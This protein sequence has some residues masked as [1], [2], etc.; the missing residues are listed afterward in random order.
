MSA[1]YLDSCS[2]PLNK[3]TALVE[4]SAGTG[5]TFAI[6]M[7]VLRA[8]TELGIPIREVLV[9]TYTKA[10]TEELRERIRKRFIEARTLVINKGEG[11]TDPVLKE[12]FDRM[13]D[14]QLVKKRLDD[15]LT[16]IDLTEIFT[17]HGFC[18]R[19]LQEHALESGQFFETELLQDT[20]S[21]LS[22]VIEDY[23]RTRVYSLDEL[24][25]RLLVSSYP[26]PEKLYK[27]INSSGIDDA[28]VI[29]ESGGIEQCSE[30]LGRAFK[31]L[32]RWF[33][34]H[35]AE[36]LSH[37]AAAAAEGKFKKPLADPEGLDVVW[38]AL[39]RFFHGEGVPEDIDLLS[40]QG[41]LERLNGRKVKK[42]KQQAF[43][44]S[45]PVADDE[46][47]AFTLA[48]DNLKLSFREDLLHHVQKELARRLYDL[49]ALSFNDLI[50]R[51]DHALHSDN[52]ELA[53]LIGKRYGAAFIDEFQDTDGSQWSIFSTLFGGGS[54]YFYLIGDP[55]QAIYKFRGAD[56]HSY[57]QARQSADYQYTLEKNYRSHPALVE[58]INHL[59][60]FS[61]KPFNYEVDRLPFHA[62]EA[63]KS[64]GEIGLVKDGR[65]LDTL[66]Y[67]QLPE[68]LES[69]KHDWKTGQARELFLRRTVIEITGLLADETGVD[70]LAENHSGEVEARPLQP[71]DIAILVRNHKEGR[72]YQAALGEIGLP[73]VIA[74]KTSV[75]SSAEC[76]EL[77]LVLD[78]IIEPANVRKLKSAMAVSWFGLTGNE[79]EALWS[80]EALFGSWFDRFLFYHQL[81]QEKGFLVMIYT[82]LRDEQV[83]LHLAAATQG[84]RR[85]TNIYHLIELVSEAEVEE[86]LG[87]SQTLSLLLSRI[88]DARGADDTELRLES[89]EEAVQIVT[90]HSAKGLQY[91]VV[92]CPC[93]WQRAAFL[94][95]EKEIVSF[96]SE[97]GLVVDIGSEEFEGHKDIALGEELAEELRLLYVA[98]TRAEARC[99]IMWADCGGDAW[100]HN[101]FES[102]LGYILFGGEKQDHAGQAAVLANFADNAGVH[103]ELLSTG[104]DPFGV[105]FHS[106]ESEPLS[107]R[108]R[109]VRRFSTDFR[110]SSYSA[111]AAL[112]EHQD[113][114]SYNAGQPEVREDNEV[115][116]ILHT[117][118]PAGASFGNLIH[119]SLEDIPFRFFDGRASTTET[120]KKLCQRYGL[121]V[122]PGAI[123]EFLRSG[124]ESRVG[125]AEELFSL[126]MLDE[127]RCL[128]EM[129][130]YFQVNNLNT[131]GINDILSHDPAVSAVSEMQMRG[132]LTGFIDLV[133][134]WQGKFYVIDY[135]TNYLGEYL[136]DYRGEMLVEAMAAHNYGLQ[137]WIYSLVLHRYLDNVLEDY[138]YETHFG[139]ALYLF[140]RGMSPA[141]PG[142]GVF[143]TVPDFDRLKQLDLLLGDKE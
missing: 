56:I 74:S 113:H 51:L 89:D 34:L 60:Q 102:G 54:H 32:R 81:W 83:V 36:L 41:L 48:A 110:M 70:C 30:E 69:N 107:A 99:Y 64:E 62:V 118:L 2:T 68:N 131:R 119:D 50:R 61:P 9:V 130:F 125:R 67:W 73:S 6:G 40:T 138:D 15:A 129:K 93:L 132:Y 103:Y 105:K 92:F 19:M 139:G 135:K 1:N 140:V 136:G 23:W 72:T 91:P 12:W 124:V 141:R 114:G 98:V 33:E 3:G 84:E 86:K 8:V 44:E 16:D 65:L 126:S 142:N 137:Y 117:G 7:L 18:Q 53:A 80:D 57:F 75:Y 111:I 29:P 26:S 133:C 100:N 88:E 127:N 78:S 95:R 90:M 121:D 52:G 14:L 59:F 13:A 122:E 35:G 79:L 134:Q 37:L 43:I 85:I 128:K 108:E 39:E 116:P 10:A 101:S 49:G 24:S 58:G 11:T 123:H 115:A 82:L 46:L 77:Y 21:L 17:I 71:G 38:G 28:T 27:S 20:S 5:K 47:F 76:E 45:W 96:H 104:R 143:H 25:C 31:H 66:I 94:R 22:E 55:K 109:G 112:T 87:P 120:L 63:A 97:D 4:A 106:D 42:D